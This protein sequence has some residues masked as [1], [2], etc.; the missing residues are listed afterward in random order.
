MWQI[1]HFRLQKPWTCISE[2]TPIFGPSLIGTGMCLPKL[3]KKLFSFTMKWPL[4]WDKNVF[5]QPAL[6]EYFREL[7]YKADNVNKFYLEG[8]HDFLCQTFAKWIKI[9]L[10]I[11]ENV[12]QHSNKYN[13]FYLKRKLNCISKKCI[14]SQCSLKVHEGSLFFIFIAS[15]HSTQ[16]IPGFSMSNFWLSFKIIWINHRNFTLKTV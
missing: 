8:H 11:F 3:L 6:P 9:I 13:P 14:T 4:T 12:C 10:K 2:I 7:H 1:R 15:V 16:R 5:H